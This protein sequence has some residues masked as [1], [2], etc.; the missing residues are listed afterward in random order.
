MRKVFF[1]V[2][3]FFLVIN[4][5]FAQDVNNYPDLIKQA[6]GF[7]EKGQFVQS[8]EK[9]EEA[10]RLL[11]GKGFIN[12]RYNAA[13]TWALA[14]EKEYAFDNLYRIVKT[15][16]YTD[17]NHIST[18]S[19][20]NSIHSDSR[21]NEILSIVKEKKEEAEANLDKKLVA[22]LDT[23]YEE[24]QKYRRQIAEIREKYGQQSAQ[25]EAHWELINEKD[26]INLIKVKQILDER[27]WLGADVIG[28]QG[29]AT[30]FLVI[31]HS[32]LTTRERYLPMMQ[33][34]VLKGNANPSSLALLEDRI[35]LGQGKK[36]IYG[37]QI[38]CDDVSGEMYI[39][40]LDDPDNV[41]K[42]R[43]KVGLGKLQDYISRWGMTWDPDEYKVQSLK[44]DS[45]HIK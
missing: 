10:F 8:G 6:W 2:L 1:S 7:Y 36:Q 38:G 42:R 34:A 24:D 30:L 11:G 16:F 35:A 32:D 37:S 43:E 15:G 17:L 13:C 28:E 23:I 33:D 40:P 29:N 19:D 27:G 21:W 5:S 39:L 18:D 22:I 9:Y 3:V 14:G 25:M 26:S 41:D 44:I 4:I 20:L 31:Q 45:L 12:D